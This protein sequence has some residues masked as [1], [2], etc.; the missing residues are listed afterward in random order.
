M[1]D[2]SSRE[3]WVGESSRTIFHWRMLPSSSLSSSTKVMYGI[4][5]RSR[6][7]RSFARR[8]VAAMMK[9]DAG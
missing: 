6:P 8:F 1:M 7:T 5:S 9:S 2:D 4:G 3:S